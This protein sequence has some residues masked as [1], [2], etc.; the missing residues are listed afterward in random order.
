[1]PLQARLDV[2][3]ALHHIIGRRVNTAPIF[4]DDFCA[5]PDSFAFTNPTPL[6]MFHASQLR[7][8]D[9][10]FSPARRLIEVST[11]KPSRALPVWRPPRRE[12]PKETLSVMETLDDNALGLP[13]VKSN[14]LN[15]QYSWQNM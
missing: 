13:F 11:L 9:Q 6:V 1:M 5:L 7:H 2:P 14:L 10:L 8:D 15:F 12:T 3:G 4:R